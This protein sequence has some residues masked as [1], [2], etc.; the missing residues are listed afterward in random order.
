MAGTAAATAETVAIEAMAAV[1]AVAAVAA[2]ATVATEEALSSK[3]SRT[4]D[5][6]LEKKCL[7]LFLSTCVS[8]VHVCHGASFLTPPPVA[9]MTTGR[10]KRSGTSPNSPSLRKSFTENMRMLPVD[11]W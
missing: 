3:F 11:L 9:S 1:A 6:E 2:T 10:L 4:V 8:G 7:S 5:C